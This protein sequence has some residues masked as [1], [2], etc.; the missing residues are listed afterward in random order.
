MS[1]LVSDR[2]PRERAAA[3]CRRFGLGVPILQA[4]MAGEMVRRLWAE[5]EALLP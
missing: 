1:V 3:F 2:S 5:A 4:P